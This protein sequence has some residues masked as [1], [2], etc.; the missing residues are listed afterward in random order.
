MHL[1]FYYFNIQ[2]V[3]QKRKQI[4]KMYCKQFL[5]ICA[6]LSFIQLKTFKLQ[7]ISFP[8]SIITATAVVAAHVNNS[9]LILHNI[10]AVDTKCHANLIN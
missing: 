4:E 5:F 2:Q 9:N 10:C 8:D 1:I 6:L 7:V 3:D